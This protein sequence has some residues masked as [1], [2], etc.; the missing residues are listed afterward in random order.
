MGFYTSSY[1]CRKKNDTNIDIDPKTMYTYKAYSKNIQQ[2]IAGLV[3][4][5]ELV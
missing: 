2:A 3:E 1:Q 4:L 5:P